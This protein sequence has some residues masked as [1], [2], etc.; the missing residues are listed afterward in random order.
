MNLVVISSMTVLPQFWW[1]IWFY[2]IRCSCEIG[3]AQKLLSIGVIAFTCQILLLLFILYLEDSEMLATIMFSSV[4]F[5]L[6]QLVYLVMFLAKINHNRCKCQIWTHVTSLVT[7]VFLLGM[8][9]WF[10]Y[11][12]LSST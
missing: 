3:I 11:C 4:L 12:F 5:Y 8:I 9:G 10:C 7:L 6:L 1:L 2:T